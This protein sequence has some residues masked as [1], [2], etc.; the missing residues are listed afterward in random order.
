[1]IPIAAIQLPT[2]RTPTRAHVLDARSMV[3]A[4]DQRRDQPSGHGDPRNE[5]V[6]GGV[7]PHGAPV[8]V[9]VT[10][11][12]Y[13]AERDQQR[14]WQGPARRHQQAERDERDGVQE[15]HGG[16]QRRHGGEHR[17][18][19]KGQ[20]K[21]SARANGQRARPAARQA[22]RGRGSARRARGRSEDGARRRRSRQSDCRGCARRAGWANAT[23]EQHAGRA[24]G[25]ATCQGAL[26]ANVPAL[27]PAQVPARLPARKYSPTQA[28]APPPMRTACRPTGQRDRSPSAMPERW[29][30]PVAITKPTP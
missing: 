2:T 23:S 26:S 30:R 27:G 8:L 7:R 5:Q 24:P 19:Q 10:E 20:R 11:P 3:A 15:T 28:I 16:E 29:S 22:G 21:R 9:A 6:H 18:E 17:A 1:M 12:E 4:L 25:E 14:Q 13:G